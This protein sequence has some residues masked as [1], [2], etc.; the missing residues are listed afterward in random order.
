MTDSM[1]YWIDAHGIDAVLAAL[2]M[3]CGLKMQE[4][5]GH[6]A[7][8]ARWW[9]SLETALNDVRDHEPLSP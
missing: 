7:R 6:D 3:I 2:S 8:A 1:K 5:A 9:L 4:C